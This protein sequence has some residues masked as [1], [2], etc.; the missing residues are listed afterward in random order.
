[1]TGIDSSNSS[2]DRERTILTTDVVGSTALLRR[3]PNEMLG[4][5][6]L[7]D[8]VLNAAISGR[9][10]S[11]F[12]HTGDGLLAV[13]ERPLDAVLAAI[14]SQRKMRSA[15]WGPIGRLQLRYGIHSG[16]TR[17][18]GPTDF[19]GPS[20][21]TAVRL[22]EAAHADQILISGVTAEQLATDQPQAPFELSDLGEHHFKGIEPIRVYQVCTS[23]LPSAFP[24]LGGKRESASGNLPAG[25]SSFL[26]RE[27][28]LKDLA[29]ISRESRVLTLI[30]P[31]GIG[32]TRLAIEFA[33]SLQLSFPDGAW[34][35]DLSALERDSEVWPA[36][37]D[38]LLIPP[39]AGG[40]RRI[41]VIE[42]LRDARAII[43]MD[44]CEH[45]LDP[46]ADAVTELGSSCGALFLI[47]TSRRTLGVEGEAL[48]EVSSLDFGSQQGPEQSA[49]V[50]LFVDRSR[51]AN[52]RFEPAPDDLALIHRICANLDHIPLAI[53]IAAGHLRRLTLDRIEKGVTK[54]LDLHSRNVRRR[55]GRQQTLRQTLE[56]SY[57][58]LDANSRRILQRLAVF[59]GPFHE[60]QALAVCAGDIPNESDVLGGI[61]ELVESSLLAR[62]VGSP[63]LM[64]MLQTVQAFGREKLDEAGLLQNVETRHGQVYA[65]RCFE[66]GQ[67]I[68]SIDEA[69]AAN[70]I[71]DEMS[72]LRAAFERAL[73]RDLKLAEDLSAPLFL[74]NYWHR[75]AET[76]KWYERIMAR[77]DADKLK[78]APILLAGA[79]GHTFHDEGDQ[80]K[81]AA[82]IERGLRAEAAGLESGKG[83]LSHVSGQMAQ[84]SGDLQA[85]I[86]H[87][88]TAVKQARCA[89]NTPCEVMS[90]CMIAFVK[91]RTGDL[92][93]AGERI[94]EAT[95]MG[96]AVLPPTLMGYI[97]YARG[98]IA[99]DSAVAIDEYQTSVEWAKMAGNH[100]GAQRVKQLI[101]DL[102][103]AKAAP[104]EAMDIHIRSLIEL[105]SHGA[106]F[107]TWLTIRSLIL[108]LAALGAD[109]ELAVLAGALLAS[110][111][112]LGRSAQDAVAKAKARLGDNAFASAAAHGSRFDPTEARRYIIEAWQ[113]MIARE[114]SRMRRTPEAP[115]G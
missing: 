26:G 75:G 110:P 13:F 113:R 70:A 112:K 90:L 55:V 5:M 10:G 73:T 102:Q 20:L 9:S 57:D 30:G 78:Q 89:N 11:V 35:V 93:G 69:K 43:L 95:Q 104:A 88:V 98:G 60:E 37:A 32:K 101:A 105:P 58:L 41:Q 27:R 84:W 74:F 56:W 87:L 97:H 38:A 17:S 53:E 18:R 103:A 91:S 28:E 34:F 15:T 68:A 1:M 19:F 36:I 45:V 79:A 80:A 96:P 85:C 107:Y 50:Q 81:A 66:L 114:R 71:Y 25:V 61:E 51:L 6:D 24:P 82:F 100:L 106:T 52:R 16:L 12:R 8:R 44:N 23:D 59:S 108:P 22:Q 111:L 54:P 49:A 39:L 33:R 65:V 29:Q 40:E 99:Q 48:Y 42:R 46:I 4:A 109:E 47:N 86:E 64:R 21:P 3:H 92:Q 14:D 67:Q 72:N 31:G 62:H 83:W 7:H 94:S 2:A 115:H 76:G 63:Q 77:P